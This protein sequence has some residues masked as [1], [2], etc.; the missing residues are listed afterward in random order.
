M[1][2]HCN[3]VLL[4]QFRYVSASASSV[5]YSAPRPTLPTKSVFLVFP[6]SLYTTSIQH[7]YP[8]VSDTTPPNQTQSKQKSNPRRGA[9]APS[10]QK[11]ANTPLTNN[12]Q[13][14]TTRFPA[15]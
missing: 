3:R 5:A 1:A 10:Q 9:R 13:P 4:R 12:T 15:T 6:I 14:A 2:I 8:P 11:C 7:T